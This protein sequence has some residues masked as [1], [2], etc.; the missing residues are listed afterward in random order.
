MCRYDEGTSKQD[1]DGDDEDVDYCGGMEIR[2][3]QEPHNEVLQNAR[4]IWNRIK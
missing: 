4:I 2:A 3:A 1:D